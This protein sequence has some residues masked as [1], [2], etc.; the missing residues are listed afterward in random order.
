MEEVDRYAK[1]IWD[2]MKFG[3]DIHP[4]DL[5]LLCGHD[6]D[7]SAIYTAEL[8]KKRFAPLVLATGAGSVK[9][10][11]GT[12]SGEAK[13]MAKVM[14]E[15]GVPESAILIEPKALNSGENVLFSK[16]L[17][18]QKG[19]SIN[20]II[21][22]HKPYMERRALATF[23]KQWPGPEYQITS[24]TVTYEEYIDGYGDKENFLNLLI[25]DLQRIREF[26]KEG[27]MIEQDIPLDVWE[28]EQKLLEMGYYKYRI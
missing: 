2:Y 17:L 27:Y 23:L 9:N 12:T 20:K 21:L 18:E 6:D 3:M 10:R 22:V 1:K 7:R 15:N 11:F 26:P 8:Y 28:A 19:I 24:M 14:S 4:A 16:A 13:R 5:L 25:G